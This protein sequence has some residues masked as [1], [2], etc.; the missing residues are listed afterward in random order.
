MTNATPKQLNDI[1]ASNSGD[2]YKQMASKYFNVPYNKVTPEQR[3]QM[4]RQFSP[5]LYGGMR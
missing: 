5:L 3:T 1:I 2:I 4:K